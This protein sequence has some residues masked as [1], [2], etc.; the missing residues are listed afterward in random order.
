[1]NKNIVKS[2]KDILNGTVKQ[3]DI[4]LINDQPFICCRFWEIYKCSL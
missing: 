2:V 3:I 4:G 1:M